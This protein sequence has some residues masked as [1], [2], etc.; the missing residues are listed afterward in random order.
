MPRS[1]SHSMSLGTISAAGGELGLETIPTVSMMGIKEELLVPFGSQN[2]AFDNAGFEPEFLHGAR[3]PFAYRLMDFRVAHNPALT[4]QTLAG[5]KLRL[6]QYNHLPTRLEQRNR[7]RQ[8]ERHRDEADV[9]GEEIHPLANLLEHQLTRVDALVHDHPRIRAKR[10]RK[11]ADADIDGMHPRRARL[12]QAVGEAS[13]RGTDIQ[14]NCAADVDMEMLECARHF[15]AA[16]THIRWRFHEC[17]RAIRLDRAPGL[18]RLLPIDQHIA[19]H[20]ERLGLLAGFDETAFHEQAVQAG[21]HPPHS[22]V[23]ARVRGGGR[24]RWRAGALR[25]ERGLGTWYL[26]PRR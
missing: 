24:D 6:D 3:H 26:S 23:G 7:G 21:L 16:A 12:Q 22:N 9:A 19:R 20:D 4:H 17:E 5:F 2:G 11:L 18:V 10:P 15:V 25:F 13:G 14:T 8:N 1:L